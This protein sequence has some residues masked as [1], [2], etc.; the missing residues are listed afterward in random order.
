MLALDSRLGLGIVFIV[1]RHHG[2]SKIEQ[3]YHGPAG[4]AATHPVFTPGAQ[5]R[6][7]GASIILLCPHRTPDSVLWETNNKP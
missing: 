7:P 4:C 6:I 2:L 5:V 1:L 3:S